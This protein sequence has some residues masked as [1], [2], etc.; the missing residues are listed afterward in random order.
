MNSIHYTAERNVQIVIALLKA[1]GIKRVIASPGTTNMTFVASIQ[2]D[3]W[4]LIWS[5]V[6][7][8][9][10]AYLACGMAAETG[11]PVVISC[12]GAT[13]SRNYMSGLTEAYYR[14][15]P[16]LAITSH[17]GTQAIG[18]L[19]D[20]QIDRRTIPNDIALESV[21]IPLVKDQADEDFCIIETNKAILALRENGGGPVH[22]NLFTQYNR[23]FSVERLPLVKKIERYKYYDTLPPIP[24]GVR[25]AIFVGSH[26]N[27]S[28]QAQKA[29]E[30][31]CASH[32][33]VVFIDQTSGYRG[34]YSIQFQ[35]VASQSFMFP[36]LA[37][38][39]LLIHIGEVSGD[40]YKMHVNREVWRVSE[41]GCL[42]DTFGKLT[43]VFQ[44]REEDF[45]EHYTEKNLDKTTYID[46]CRK[47]LESLMKQMPELPFGN[48]WIAKQLHDILPVNS[49]LHL[50]IYNSLRSW[51]FF[52][53]P[54]GVQAKCNVGGFGIDGGVSSMIGA[55]FAKPNKL[56]FGIFGDLAF[57]YD[58]N[59][60]GNRHIGKNVRILLITNGR[61]TEFRLKPHPCYMFGDKADDFLCAAGHFG[62]KSTQIVKHYAADLEFEYLCASN[63]EEFLKV[64]TRFTT[65]NFLDKPIILEA[66]TNTT[67]ET[68]ALE[69]IT[70][71]ACQGYHEQMPLLKSVKQKVKSIIGENRIKGIKSIIDNKNR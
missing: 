23:D 1:H 43:K 2:N 56:F 71:F 35:L 63:K 30:G 27:F 8:R 67:E 7:E 10:A 28:K 36:Q 62:N 60:L 49:E 59:V 61:G 66:F 22:I 48:I 69:I 42:R 54:Q 65:P 47:E 41:D 38:I 32:D 29:I 24:E 21:T 57:F 20:Q 3:P 39:D 4:F 25:I 31:F 50:G 13:A 40:C 9:S 6:D 19:H 18:H 14:K 12:T 17:R 55:S 70:H 26:Q 64:A 53:L 34:K 11:E 15:L 5:S 58:M 44:M 51:N 33:A 52:T 37:E 46:A 16:V 68:D 45:F